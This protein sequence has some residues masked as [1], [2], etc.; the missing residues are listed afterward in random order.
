M[1][2]TY[3]KLFDNLPALIEEAAKHNIVHVEEVWHRDQKIMEGHVTYS[4]GNTVVY[5]QCG[6][7]QQPLLGHD[8]SIGAFRCFFGH[9]TSYLKSGIGNTR[10][11]CTHCNNSREGQRWNADT[12][13]METVV[14]GCSYCGLKRDK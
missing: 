4:N 6:F 8:T 9:I 14:E 1:A 2:S 5:C 11:T 12:R 7:C 3:S 13:M 10:P